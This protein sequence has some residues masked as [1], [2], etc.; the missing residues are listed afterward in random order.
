MGKEQHWH[1]LWCARRG[2][3]GTDTS[4]SDLLPAE[5]GLGENKAELVQDTCGMGGVSKKVMNLQGQGGP[6]AAQ[7]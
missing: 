3:S 1:R 7:G 4:C 5:P 6:Q 2:Q